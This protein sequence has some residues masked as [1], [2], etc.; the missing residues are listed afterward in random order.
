MSDPAIEE[1]RQ[2]YLHAFEV[3]LTT[4]AADK[5]SQEA[6]AAADAEI[7]LGKSVFD[8]AAKVAQEE[9]NAKIALARASYQAVV[10]RENAAAQE[11]ADLATA[12]H[13]TLEAE[14]TAFAKHYGPSLFPG[15]APA[16]SG[17]HTR[18]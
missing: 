1:A 11:K 15:P 7:A 8:N 16:P 17:G 9:M 6:R 18:L 2:A 4:S 12:A 14:R 13:V 10:T 5:A 3:L